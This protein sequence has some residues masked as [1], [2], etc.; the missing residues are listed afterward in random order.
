MIATWTIMLCGSTPPTTSTCWSAVT[1]AFTKVA[2]RGENWAYKANLPLTQFYRVSVDNSSPFYHVYGGT[3]D[4]NSM[5]GPSR[6]TSRAGITNEDWFVTVGGDGYE[7]QVDPEDP[8]IVY[9]QWQYG[10][11]VRHD[12][13]SGET[14][15]IK[16]REAPGEE[17]YRWNWD[18]PTVDKSARTQA[19]LLCRQPIVSIGRRR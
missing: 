15:D 3:Q 2:T 7:T 9:A 16:P 14:V 17:P 11:L 13:R 10:G 1:V 19:T 6:T 4:N 8:N 12:R 18:S 5:G